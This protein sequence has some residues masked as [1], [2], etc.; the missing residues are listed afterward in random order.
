MATQLEVVRL[1]GPEFAAVPDA[2]VQNFLDLAPLY[3]DP[4][5]IPED[6]RGL[7]L[8]LQACILMLS[9]SESASGQSHGGTITREKEGDLE[10]SY[11]F[12]S[13]AD[14]AARKNIYEKQLD[15]LYAG[16]LGGNI[17]TRY[18]STCP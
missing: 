1:I 7:A 18:G 17:M 10:R 6:R 8:A 9:Q 15:A 5:R 14:A 3:I 16:I 11:G 4:E 13:S 2:T 12:S